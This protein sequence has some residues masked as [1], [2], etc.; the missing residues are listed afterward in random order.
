MKTLKISLFPVIL[1]V[2]SMGLV[3]VPA[4][5]KINVVTTLPSFADIAT[6]VGGDE[7]SVV[8]LTRGTQDPHFVDARPDLVLKLN[9]ANVII[10]AGLGLE[11]GWLPPL[12]VGARNGAIQ[13]GGA[14]N[15]NVGTL[16]ALKDRAFGNMDR[17]A[18]DVHPG[19]NPHYMLDPNNGV[20]LAKGLADKLAQLEPEKADGFH[21]RADDYSKKLREKITLWEKESKS[22]LSGKSVVTYHRSWI[23]L[24]EWLG[25]KTL[26]HVEPKPGIPPSPGH[27]VK[28]V[29]QMKNA[30]IKALI[31]EPFYPRGVNEDVAQQTGAKLLVLPAEVG[32]APEAKTY[33]EMF[34]VILKELRAT[35]GTTAATAT[36]TPAAK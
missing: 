15:L 4:F 19:G 5:A 11:D 31:M 35:L 26:S 34:D 13:L 14:G 28:L 7:V 23:Y 36:P 1:S 10:H 24:T 12:L 18:G 32:G 20:V 3:G 27:I 16:M 6:Q 25:I 29:K 8:S 22:A 17:S 9:K 30:Q 33:I 2:L 21:K